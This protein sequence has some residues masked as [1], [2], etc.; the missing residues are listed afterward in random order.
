MKVTE[1]ATVG[2][3]V[4]WVT[5]LPAGWRLMRIT[6]GLRL[7]KLRNE[8]GSNGDLLSLSVSRGI[9]PKCYGDDTHERSGD[10]LR[11]YFLVK[12]D[13]FVVNPMWLMHGSLGTARISGV[14]SPDYRVYHLTTDVDPRYLHHLLKTREY[15]DLYALLARGTTTYDRR[16][17]KDC[18]NDLPLLV[19]PL[20]A[21][22]AIADFL[23]RKTAAID[24][25]I[26]KKRRLVELLA[27]KRAALIN[28]AVTK[29][30]DPTVPMKDSGIP[31][32]G[33]IPAHW[34]VKKTRFL[35]SRI[36]TGATPPTNEVD[37]YSDG[38]IPWYAPGSF[39]SDTL[40]LS[41][42]KALLNERVWKA[43]VVPKFRNGSV[44]I[45]G[46]GATLG[47]VAHL[48]IEA[49][50]NQQVLALEF[51][52]AVMDSRFAAYQY[53]YRESV[54]RDRALYTTLPIMNQDGIAEHHAICPNIDE[55]KAIVVHI[56]AKL[57]RMDKTK[58][59]VVKQI[60]HL[61]EYRQALI[62]AA[63][64]GQLEIPVD[65]SAPKE[66]QT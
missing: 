30:L 31:W 32:I 6:R 61:Q 7:S 35:C 21:Q 38:I 53:K 49:T 3:T 37:L 5:S 8:D 59:L 36:K 54:F 26:E 14:I 48:D 52:P 13:Q 23:D 12:P 2:W 46:I 17:S 42:P 28:C 51:N 20:A 18:F 19:P 43:N 4:P 41:D 22:R 9:V 1:R 65:E 56:E 62:T 45:V 10:E 44:L 63:V 40:H 16:I 57:K 11:K 47:K 15:M 34:E 58:S 55:Q 60:T 33:E 50:A 24:A 27:E 39:D 64:T 25:L 29:G 66:A